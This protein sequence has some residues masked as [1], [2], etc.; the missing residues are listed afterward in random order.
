[1]GSRSHGSAQGIAVCVLA[2]AVLAPAALAKTYRPTRRDDPAPNGCH[3]HDCSLREA[4]TKANNH[5]G[6]DTIVLKGGK[7][8]D[9]GQANVSGDENFN[10]TGDID[11]L[12][13]LTL[14]SSNR[15][16]ATINAH[17]IDRVLQ[18]GSMGAIGR[19]TLKRLHLEHGDAT[20][21]SQV[22]G[23]IVDGEGN[24]KIVHSV[25]SGNRA[26]SG[27]GVYNQYPKTTTIVKSTIKGNRAVGGSGA[28]GGL[29]VYDGAAKVV[30]STING[31][32]AV[33]GGGIFFY[34]LT[35]LNATNST[36]ANNQASHTGG[37]IEE[38][39]GNPG[40]SRLKS[41]TIARNQAD[42]NGTTIGATGGLVAGDP[43]VI[44]RNSII[45]LNTVGGSGFPD[46]LG[47]PTPAG[48]SLL[49]EISGCPGFSGAA[50]VTSTPRLGKLAD[51]GG[52][53]K[54]I[55]LR[56]HSKAI[57]HA[58]AGSPPRDQRGHKRHNPD[59]GAFER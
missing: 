25:I 22:G 23:G 48:K 54:T 56:R 26:S 10:A 55:A 59:I 30:D 6:P 44:V 11:I 7:T 34:G 51:N 41:V 42:P 14:K 16:L 12:Q 33:F 13:A 21:T 45:A 32:H 2:L 15:K 18:T 39:G 40:P 27:G 36:I 31:N 17:G 53:T 20:V 43:N 50:I 38:S 19:V 49:T 9:L 29:E 24:V 1:M 46:C 37:G 35:A 4:V 8:Y 28:G 47:S 5:S 58:G 3:K 52:P 57:N